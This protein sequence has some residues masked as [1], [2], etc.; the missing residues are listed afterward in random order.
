MQ[1]TT[2]RMFG[3]VTLVAIAVATLAGCNTRYGS[4]LQRFS[5]PVVLTGA[6]VPGLEG[7]DPQHVVAFSHDGSTW[8]QIPVQVDERD[9]VSP[10]V[11]QHLPT[12]AYPKLSGTS[13]P[14]KILV[15]T[16]PPTTTAGYT[17]WSTYTPPD[18]DPTLDANDEISFLASDAGRTTD[19]AAPPGVDATS[20]TPLH[21]T[22]PIDGHTGTV[23]L[24][25]SA[26]LTGG[27]AGTTAVHYTFS[28]DSG[29]YR[30][31]YR[32]GPSALA[33]NNANGPN[34]EHSTV[35]T[36]FYSL[37][38][39]D[40]WL[41]DALTIRQSGSSG[42]DLLD[43][44][45]YFATKASCGRTED[46][47]DA[48]LGYTGEFVV[49][50]SGPVRAIRSVMGANSFTYTV[51]TDVFYPNRQDSTIELRGHAGMPGF[52]SA[53]DLTTGLAGM[54]YS[55]PANTGVPIDGTPDAFTPITAAS[56]SALPPSWQVVS[57]PAGTMITTHSL[58]TDITG[59][60][61]ASTFVDESGT[62]D[63]TG[64][65]S[66]WGQSGITVNS[67]VNNVPVTDP[68]LSANPRHF[69]TERTRYFSGPD[70]PLAD[71]PA[72]EVRSH[73]PIAVTVG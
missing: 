57:G 58:T 56:G 60:E 36:P 7:A 44:S 29:D 31:T 32:I 19:A 4:N 34:P 15:Y 71:A 24:F 9:L 14:Y 35:D 23:Y 69:T 70:F 39:S 62:K 22:D 68:T 12:S 37:G 59:L 53:D 27:S 17:T 65:D 28:L 11:I 41:N 21:L 66:T 8:H 16:P 51:L 40:R 42:A 47:F 67:P 43:R 5:D 2:R 6:Q 26:T 48:T 13:T 55:D 3:A 49:N 64:D 10:G 1:R 25:T 20:R 50:L 61:V 52:G 38:F 73:T 72:L 18:G 54:T 33:P 46:T 30:A 45:K 63:C